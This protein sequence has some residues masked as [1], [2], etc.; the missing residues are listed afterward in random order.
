MKIDVAMTGL[1][2]TL[3][4]LFYMRPVLAFELTTK[5]YSIAIVEN[6]DDDVACQDISFT[7]T[8]RL[9]GKTVHLKGRAVVATCKDDV[10]ACHH[11]GYEFRDGEFVYFVSDQEDWLEVSKN[12][13]VV[14]HE[15]IIPDQASST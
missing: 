14:L 13:K 2:I 7:A 5:T 8:N 9:I 10:T 3:G 12:H 6:C 4:A 1:A 11:L 15:A